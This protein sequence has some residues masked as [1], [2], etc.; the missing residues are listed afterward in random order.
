MDILN[1]EL[2]NL[3]NL[4]KNY[5]GVISKTKKYVGNKHYFDKK[6]TL[7]IEINNALK[8]INRIVKQDMQSFKFVE[9]LIIKL[10]SDDGS[11]N[12]EKLKLVDEIELKWQDLRLDLEN[13]QAFQEK[14]KIPTTSS[15]LM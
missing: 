3:Y 13:F 10:I 7:F 6:K 11:S 5:G 12:D 1:S 9:S 4:V 14:Y 8:K 2:E 15:L